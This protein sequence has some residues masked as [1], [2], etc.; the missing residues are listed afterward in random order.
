MVTI[1]SLLGSDTS[2]CDSS[3]NF[4]FQGFQADGISFPPGFFQSSSSSLTNPGGV[5]RNPIAIGTTGGGGITDFWERVSDTANT[6]DQTA[7]AMKFTWR[8]KV[9]GSHYNTSNHLRSLVTAQN[10]SAYQSYQHKLEIRWDS[11]SPQS[12]GSPADSGIPPN[13]NMYNCLVWQL[14]QYD[15]AATPL[16]AQASYG[17]PAFSL[18]WESGHFRF[19]IT[20]KDQYMGNILTDSGGYTYSA[21]DQADTINGS[22][23]II[24]PLP[25]SYTTFLFDFYLDEKE[26][27]DGGIGY[28]KLYVGGVL[29][30]DYVGPTL[31]PLRP[32]DIN[33]QIITPQVAY[34]M[35]FFNTPFDVNSNNTVNASMVNS[36]NNYNTFKNCTLLV[37]QSI[38]MSS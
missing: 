29:I 30:V 5:A 17:I 31:Q 11:G 3:G 27:T 23:Y 13:D 36:T 26:I 16:P 10:L 21:F 37:R 20:R 38:L 1:F 7:P 4:K 32:A 14:H 19:G 33:Y 22:S 6:S 8:M 15:S 2:L 35:Y 9:S 28:F 24:N 25:G 34:G 18:I 12:V